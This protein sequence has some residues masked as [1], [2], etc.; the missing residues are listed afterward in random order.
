MTS[1]SD[2]IKMASNMA[3]VYKRI[4]YNELCDKYKY[5]LNIQGH[6]QVWT[7]TVNIDT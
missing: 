7:D 2:I 6:K 3:E 1:Q 4:N 5:K